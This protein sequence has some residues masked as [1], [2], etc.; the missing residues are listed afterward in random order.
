MS[1]KW[2]ADE[3]REDRGARLQA[4]MVTTRQD[5]PEVWI[6][7]A[8]AILPMLA[9]N[10]VHSDPVKTQEAV[11]SLALRMPEAFAAAGLIATAAARRHLETQN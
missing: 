10:G 3:T 4:E 6:A 2:T 8:A 5:P 9:V 7:R 11:E 1:N